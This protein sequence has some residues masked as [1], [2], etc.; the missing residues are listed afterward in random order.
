VSALPDVPRLDA[1][2]ARARTDRFKENAAGLWAE[3][4]SLYEDGAHIALGY[5]SWES[6][7]ADE[8]DFKKSRAYQLL[9][10]GRVQSLLTDS[11]MVESPNERVAREL[12]PLRNEPETLR[13]TWAEVVD[14]H[15]DKP[16]AAQVKD[17]VDNKVGRMSVHYSSQTDEWATPQDFF[18]T[19]NA[20]FGF[21]LDACAL[22]S[23]AKCEHF[24]SPETDGLAQDWTG[25]VWMNPPYGDVIGRWV[26]KA[27]ESAT[28]GAT[29]VCLVPARTDTA[30]FHDFC[31]PWE[32]RFIRSR[33]RFGAADASAP[34]PSCLVAMGARFWQRA[35]GWD[36]R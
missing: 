2:T 22:E 5:A 10:A 18:D 13:E 8:F 11:T 24:F 28:A 23:S 12:A 20:E 16:T 4:V 15:G 14:L 30:W 35:Y 3:L 1:A 34:F 19:V 29:V 33:L 26:Q 32:V 7:C 9:D 21:T 17:V 31:F 25:T 36:W 27:H 6:Y